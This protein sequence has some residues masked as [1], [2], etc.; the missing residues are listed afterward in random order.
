MIKKHLNVHNE[1]KKGHAL[2]ALRQHVKIDHNPSTIDQNQILRVAIPNL[3]DNDVIIPSTLTV[4]FDIELSSTANTRHIVNNIGKAIITS[5]GI[6]YGSKPVYTIDDFDIFQIYKDR[7]LSKHNQSLLI[8]QGIDNVGNINKVRV[9]AHGASAA[10]SDKEKA[11]AAAYSKTFSIPIGTYFEVTKHLPSVL[12]NDRLTF[13]LRFAPYGNVIVDPGTGSGATAKAADGKYSISN[14][15]LEFDQVT[16]ANTAN[17]ARAQ[18]EKGDLMYE[19]IM[20]FGDFTVKKAADSFN[21]SVNT[22]SLSLTGVLLLFK[23]DDKMK[24]YSMK[25][26]EFYNPLITNVEITVESDTHQLYT[27]GMTSRE[28]YEEAYGYFGQENTAMGLPE[29]FSDGYCLFVDFRTIPDNTLHGAGR[30]LQ[31]VSNGITLKVT[32]KKQKKADGTEDTGD[33]ICRLFTIT[34]PIANFEGGRL[35]YFES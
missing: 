15:C 11:V 28:M 26:E 4:S 2:Q 20:R 14:I 5:L 8:K 29:F 12:L 23:E 27:H 32:K 31:N 9:G 3:G 17:E 22:A 25:H 19:R 16:D 30:E 35:Q 6:Q 21:V 24:P 1:Y 13:H 33:I 18:L 7:W 34:D 10:A